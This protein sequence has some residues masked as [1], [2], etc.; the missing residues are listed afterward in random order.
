MCPTFILEWCRDVLQLIST[1]VTM[2]QA[3]SWMNDH[4]ADDE[5]QGEARDENLTESLWG[6]LLSDTPGTE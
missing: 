5:R 2:G 3:L 1:F 4:L 6:E